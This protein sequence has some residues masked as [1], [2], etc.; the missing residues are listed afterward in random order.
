MRDVL[1]GLRALRSLDSQADCAVTAVLAVPEVNR[2]KL[3]WELLEVLTE[4]SGWD[5]PAILATHIPASDLR[6]AR[7]A[8]W[9]ETE[10]A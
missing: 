2:V 7:E 8:L 9:V 6:L 1:E 3:G 4:G 5:S 10:V